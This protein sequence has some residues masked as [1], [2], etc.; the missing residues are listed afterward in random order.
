MEENIE[1]EGNLN[2]LKC[3]DLGGHTL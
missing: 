3:K 1:Q 2:K